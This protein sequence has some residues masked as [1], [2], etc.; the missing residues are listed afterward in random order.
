MFPRQGEWTEDE[1][2]ELE[3]N[4]QNRLI[5]LNDGRLEVLPR[6][7]PYHQGIVRYLFRCADRHATSA[8]LGEVF[9]APLPIRLWANQL[10]EPDLVFLKK[11]RLTHRR[12]P[13]DG[14]DLVM[15]VVSKGKN[16][17]QRDLTTKRRLYARAR[18]GEYWIV[19]PEQQTITVLVLAG[20]TY[21][22][23]GKFGPG[24]RATS[25]V[26][27]GFAVE[28]DQVFAAGTGG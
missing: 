9:F 16:N 11:D 24:A 6:P 27:P 7:D 5:E 20:K 15:E 18:I 23:H 25:K 4:A 28:V 17:R 2:L 21:K 8:D 12:R 14:A 26:L 13:P 22:V 1:Y 19:D 10:R 3:D